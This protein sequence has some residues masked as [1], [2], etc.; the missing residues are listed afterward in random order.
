MVAEA[1]DRG[2][3]GDMSLNMHTLSVETQ[4]GLC[5]RRREI[6]DRLREFTGMCARDEGA[7]DPAELALG[8][9]AQ[10]KISY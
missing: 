1:E 7:V 2:R 4:P 9:V 5:K 3:Y 6:V 10:A 8:K